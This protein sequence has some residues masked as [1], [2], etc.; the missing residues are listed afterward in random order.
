MQF[1]KYGIYN[2]CNAAALLIVLGG[3]YVSPTKENL[4]H[5]KSC[6]LHRVNFALKNIQAGAP[7]TTPLQLRE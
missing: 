1:R 2:A 3:E 5:Q 6:T 7:Q 4:Y